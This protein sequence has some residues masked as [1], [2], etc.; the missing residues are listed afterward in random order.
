VDDDEEPDASRHAPAQAP[1]RAS[2]SASPLAHRCYHLRAA[3]VLEAL[4]RTWGAGKCTVVVLGA[5]MDGLALASLAQ[6]LAGHMGNGC[7]LIEVDCPEVVERK[8]MA[9]R[10]AAAAAGGDGWLSQ[11]PL[12]EAGRHYRLVAADLRDQ[13]A[14]ARSLAPSAD[15][16]E[17]KEGEVL[18][19]LEAVLG[20]L[21]PER[22]AALLRYLT[23]RLLLCKAA[24]LPLLSDDHDPIQFQYTT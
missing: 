19:V 22:A 20:Y 9:L 21:P 6:A 14:V 5:G 7:R 1:A 8:Q 23:A 4:H 24:P 15:E 13:E 10:K 18:F 16:G 3:V 2:S 12:L 17:E 11:L